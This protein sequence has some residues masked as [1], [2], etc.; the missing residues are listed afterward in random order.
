M[1]LNSLDEPE[2]AKLDLPKFG[3]WNAQDGTEGTRFGY[4]FIEVLCD[5]W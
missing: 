1:E 4:W 5:E 3:T 2:V